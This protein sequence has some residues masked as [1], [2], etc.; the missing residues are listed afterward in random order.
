[1]AEATGW[2]VYG[3][4]ESAAPVE[5]EAVVEGPLA[6]LVDRVP[7]S[8]FGEGVL[9][10]RLNDRAWLEVHAQAHQDVLQAAASAAAVVPF[11]FGTI[12]RDAADVRAMLRDRRDELVA[13]LERVR[14]RVELGVK[15][16]AS[17]PEP[18]REARPASGRA[19]LEQR[20]GAQ[21]RDRRSMQL[22]ADAARDAHERLRAR[23]EGAVANRPQPRELTG[24]DETMILNGAY[25][26]ADE[27]PLREEVARLGDEYRGLGVEFEVTGPW[28]PY[29]FVAGGEDE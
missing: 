13:A 22:L 8:E 14:G 21:E 24:R 11:R 10:Q 23:A 27:V 16:W 26:V 18:A 5:V 12:Y 28:P 29:N 6:A 4:V 1:M 7:L 2:Y 25:L 17:A 15:A 19:Y 9:E 20:L 3:V